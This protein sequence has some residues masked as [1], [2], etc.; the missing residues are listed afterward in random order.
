L[1][2]PRDLNDHGHPWRLKYSL[3]K[4]PEVSDLADLPLSYEDWEEKARKSLS[5]E[6]FAY[7]S[8]GAG[9]GEAVIGN[10]EE[11]RRWKLIPR[12]LRDTSRRTSSTEVLGVR[13]AVPLMLAPVR[14]LA[15]VREKG[16][17]ICARAAARCEVPLILSNL[18]S[19]PPEVVARLMGKT[20]HFF[21]LYPCSDSEVVDSLIRRA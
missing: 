14:G 20:P 11:L 21:Q 2:T 12:V 17:E 7:V 10:N 18:A 1:S 6:R 8:A 19:A 15:Y 16:E 4:I 3:G 9:R 5:D 13:L